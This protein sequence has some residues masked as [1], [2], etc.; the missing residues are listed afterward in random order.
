MTEDYASVSGSSHPVQEISIS[1][2]ESHLPEA[3]AER[4]SDQQFRC[5]TSLN[6]EH[7]T[8]HI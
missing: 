7:A 4:D 2:Q 1:G 5:I 6:H 3:N 8:Y